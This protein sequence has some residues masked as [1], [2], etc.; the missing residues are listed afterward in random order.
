MLLLVMP[1]QDVMK[2]VTEV[3]ATIACMLN[4]L[5]HLPVVGI[6]GYLSDAHRY[7]SLGLLWHH[8]FDCSFLHWF[9]HQL[10]QAMHVR[11]MRLHISKCTMSRKIIQCSSQPQERP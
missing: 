2:E 5:V 1:M 4:D 6:W 3:G 8:S 10:W 9:Q 7:I 11:K